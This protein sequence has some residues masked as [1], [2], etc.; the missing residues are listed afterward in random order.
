M[1]EGCL[2]ASTVP[3]IFGGF[4]LQIDDKDLVVRDVLPFRRRPR[5]AFIELATSANSPDGWIARLTGG[6]TIVFGSGIVAAIRRRVGFR[7]IDDRERVVPR[8]ARDRLAVLVPADLLVVADDHRLRTRRP[9]GQ[10]PDKC[11]QSRDPAALRPRQSR[12]IPSVCF[13]RRKRAAGDAAPRR[14]APQAAAVVSTGGLDRNG[15]GVML[16]PPGRAVPVAE[17]GIAN[18]C[19]VSDDRRAEPALRQARAVAGRGDT[20]AAR[21]HRRA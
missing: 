16:E 18:G 3:T 12:H 10:R 6:P 14:A 13:R 21:P 15:R 7:D 20:G 17:G 19:R 11:R 1:P 9:D 8:L 4:C 5:S 2:P